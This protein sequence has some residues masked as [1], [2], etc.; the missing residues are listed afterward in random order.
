MSYGIQI[1]NGAGTTLFD[2]RFATG[3]LLIDMIEIGNSGG[4]ATNTYPAYAGFTI[5]WIPLYGDTGFYGASSSITTD[6]A[7]GYPRITVTHPA[8]I[9]VGVFVK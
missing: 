8:G 9:M 2:S 6:Y 3:G 5:F 1:T 4:S 7:L